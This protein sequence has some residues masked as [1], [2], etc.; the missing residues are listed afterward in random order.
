MINGQIVYPVPQAFNPPPAPLPMGAAMFGGPA[1]MPQPQIPNGG[2]YLQAQF[3]GFMPGMPGPF[4]FPGQQMPMMM[5][6]LLPAEMMAPM[7]PY[8]PMRSMV[9]Q[10]DIMRGQIQ[11]LHHQVK[12]LDH[13]LANNRHQIDEHATEAQ[14]AIF[15]GQIRNMELMLEYQAAQE[16]NV[17]R[18][19]HEAAA[20][21]DTT[22]VPPVAH[23]TK[24]V[25]E[26]ATKLSS[27][28]LS[29]R[30]EEN[31]LATIVE[32]SP[33]H[34]ES[35]APHVEPVV[36][37]K[38]SIKAPA[39]QP[40]SRNTSHALAIVPPNQSNNAAHGG[41]VQES[42]EGVRETQEQ[43]EDRLASR[44]TGKYG[45][46]DRNSIGV[47]S[48]KLPKV[49]EHE[50][51]NYNPI[52]SHPAT[53]KQMGDFR[54]S[55]AGIQSRPVPYLIG[56]L[57]LGINANLATPDDFNYNR[58][59][60]DEEV[61]ARHLYWGKAPISAQH[62]LPKFDG[63]DFYPPSPVKKNA[64]V[65]ASYSSMGSGVKHGEQ[66]YVSAN[67]A[68]L[69]TEPGVPGYKQPSPARS[70]YASP[71]VSSVPHHVYSSGFNGQNF[72]QSPKSFY[73]ETKNDTLDGFSNLFNE[74]GVSG[75]KAPTG[76]VLNSGQRFHSP[77]KLDAGSPMTLRNSRYSKEFSNDRVGAATNGS[78]HANDENRQRIN[79]EPDTIVSSSSTQDC[80]NSSRSSVNSGQS[81]E[82]MLSPRSI[83]QK[84]FVQ[85]VENF[86]R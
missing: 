1:F 66:D 85:R 86:R 70:I 36:K 42:V 51:V 47:S 40:R 13:Q 52:N 12:L 22:T 72:S 3:P 37:S 64:R 24:H 84:E 6:G 80:A 26:D 10:P 74:P 4:M 2:G 73:S 55:D 59:L 78:H 58:P 38:L 71:T 20:D 50:A 77:P 5:P 79:S 60:T 30:N 63:K 57:R 69:F 25:D 35:A 49:V 44:A 11:Q 56:S 8:L 14:R 7:F 82:R 18:G 21:S 19:H 46:S 28:G 33:G 75:Y 17:A 54:S 23:S 53:P 34:V 48:V 16:A 9:P 27:G 15:L 29:K 43:I 41:H 45:N 76:A 61:R 83:H 31:K 32:G 67:F 39:F 81:P 65:D 68:N 62:G